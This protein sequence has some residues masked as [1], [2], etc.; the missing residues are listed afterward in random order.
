MARYALVIQ[1]LR[2]ASPASA[3]QIGNSTSRVRGHVW[4]QVDVPKATTAS[5]QYTASG[6]RCQLANASAAMTIR[7][8]APSS[9]WNSKDVLALNGCRKA[10]H[11][12]VLS[13]CAGVD[14][15][16]SQPVRS[17]LDHVVQL[18]VCVLR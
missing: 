8:M 2:A 5:P 18:P 1:G 6:H 15:C 11:Q 10:A 3:A 4:Y 12:V 14:R 17:A 9:T 7:A 13:A 16:R